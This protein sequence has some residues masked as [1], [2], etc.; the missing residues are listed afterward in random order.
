M[1]LV[2]AFFDTLNRRSLECY[3]GDV[4]TPNF[5]RLADRSVTF[6]NHYAGS[7]P[8]MPARR[9]M[10]TGRYNF[11]HRSWGP[12]EPFDH[13]FP[14]ILFQEKGVYS[15]LVTDH[16]HYWKDG[17]ATYHS[18]YDSYEFIR[19]QEMDPWKGFVEP[20]FDEWR[21]KYHP[22]QFDTR[23][24]SKSRRNMVNRHYIVNYEDYP[25]VQ[26]VTAGLEFI[27]LNKD[28][29][30]WLLQIETF[31]PHE[32]F[33]VPKTFREGYPTDYNGPILDH[34]PYGDF[35]GGPDEIAELRANYAATLA[36]C[37]YQ[38]GRILDVF[39]THDMWKDTALIVTTD[40]G[41]LLGEHDLW[42][43]NVMP[44][45][46]EV[47][48]IPLFIFLPEHA[49]RGGERRKGLTQTTDLMP[50]LLDIFGVTPPPEVRGMSLLPLVAADGP[51]HET[52]LYGQH[53][54]AINITDG[55]YTYFRY[56]TDIFD[57]NLYQYTLM[58][59][60]IMSMFSVTELRNTTLAR[61]FD[62]T[63]GVPVMKVPVI[64][65]SPFF[66]RHGPGVLTDCHTRL[67]DLQTDP[68]QSAPIHDPD[69]EK[70]LSLKIVA[71]MQ[72]NDAPEE[73]YQR[74]DLTEYLS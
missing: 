18:R 4:K 44:C 36:H 60:H 49:G 16:S 68:T 38:L 51:G 33:D 19:G 8:C 62:F 21:K 66:K 35:D 40:H 43:K 24:R 71:M 9:E 61:P 46:N 5:N 58:P 67:F 22:A 55:R 10:M 57:G 26:T 13:A 59:T 37:D 30:N 29:D 48:H 72:D 47:A 45:F 31:D 25:A 52:I 41:F 32:P 70:R 6:D 3:G 27:D 15:H 17:G 7:L 14:E 53:G 12:C 28:A 65:E 50:T 73:L 39:D 20:P 23:P 63:Q 56:P 69:V 2:F 34:P 74:F 11:L 1:R 42:A 64:P 54:S